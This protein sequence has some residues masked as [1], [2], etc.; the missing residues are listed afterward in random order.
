M[1]YRCCHFMLLMS[2]CVFYGKSEHTRYIIWNRKYNYTGIFYWTVG[3]VCG[4][5]HQSAVV[6]SDQTSRLLL[7]SNRSMKPVKCLLSLLLTS[8]ILFPTRITPYLPAGIWQMYPRRVEQGM[9]FRAQSFQLL[10][11]AI[12]P[13]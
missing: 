10:S 6:L 3:L 11:C 4:D 1:F 8:F 7:T 5:F 13:H 12:D 9:L 2:H